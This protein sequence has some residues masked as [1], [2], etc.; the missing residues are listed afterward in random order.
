MPWEDGGYF[1]AISE[2]EQKAGGAWILG[3]KPHC[4]DPDFPGLGA[5]GTRPLVKIWFADPSR[6]GPGKYSMKNRLDTGLHEYVRVVTGRLDCIVRYAQPHEFVHRLTFGDDGIDLPPSV[7]RKWELP[8]GASLASGVTIC[9]PNG[10]YQAGDGHGYELR[11]WDTERQPDSEPL[12]GPVNL[13]SWRYEL[14]VPLQGGC[15]LLSGVRNPGCHILEYGYVFLP[16][17]E[18]SRWT[19]RPTYQ[20]RGVVIYF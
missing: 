19:V 4:P 9:R 3:D 11:F 18:R 8:V 14:I 12:N 10:R 6:Y 16:S 5:I 15:F 1:G 20:S 7:E 17:E 2:M 13:L